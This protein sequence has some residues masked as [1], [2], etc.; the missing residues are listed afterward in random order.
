MNTPTLISLIVCFC[1]LFALG[2]LWNWVVAE[3]K[4]IDKDAKK[5]ME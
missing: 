2:T 3:A 5:E 4:V 1:I